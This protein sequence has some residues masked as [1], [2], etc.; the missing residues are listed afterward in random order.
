M[1]FSASFFSMDF[2]TVYVEHPYS[3]TDSAT[4]FTQS[5]DRAVEYTDFT[6]AEG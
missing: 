5:A 1:Y 4:T 2:A 3:S 6:S